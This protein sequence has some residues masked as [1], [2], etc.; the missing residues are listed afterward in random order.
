MHALCNAHLCYISFSGLQSRILKMELNAVA[1]GNKTKDASDLAKHS[2]SPRN[3]LHPRSPHV[4]HTVLI[5]PLL[6]PYMV[7]KN[8]AVLK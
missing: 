8:Y 2:P 4:R 6:C 3:K 5:Q 7:A 1:G